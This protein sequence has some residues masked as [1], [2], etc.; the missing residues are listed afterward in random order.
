MRHS[1]LFVSLGVFAACS[2]EEEPEAFVSNCEEPGVVCTVSGT[3]GIASFGGEDLPA[4]ESGMYLPID[5]TFH[6]DG[7]AWVIDWNNHRIRQI[8][9]EGIIRTVSGTGFL[10]DGPEGD[11]RAAAYNHPTNL[12]FNP[13]DPNVLAIA[14]WHN[15]RIELLHLDTHELEFV[16][17]TG[18]RNYNGEGE[19][20][21]RFLDLPSSVTW[22]AAGE[23]LYFMDQANQL[24]RLLTPDGTV[25]D[26]CGHQ[27]D[28]GYNGDGGPARD[29]VLHA[30]TG[31]SADPSNRIEMF[32]GRLYIADSQNHVVRMIDERGIIDTIAG[33]GGGE[34]AYD[35]DGGPALE[36]RFALPRDLAIDADGEIFVADTDNSCIRVIHP[37]GIVDTFAGQCDT[38]G[39]AGDNGPALDA[40]FDRPYGLAVDGEGNVFVADTYNHVI[41]KITR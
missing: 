36:A 26:V 24:I 7:T 11:A 40:V 10:G 5:L 12:A 34:P 20:S 41:R 18:D 2:G 30:S 21:T 25:R 13:V 28:P 29:A 4:V 37:D 31:Q 32:D 17:G 35:G 6:E 39:F 33:L 22:D 15:S 14:A 38:R 9:A 27:R 23:N 8:D 1:L 16:A 3:P 19:A